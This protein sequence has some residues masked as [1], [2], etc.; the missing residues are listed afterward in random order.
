MREY[1]GMLWP[2]V[3]FFS[4]D[5][6][7]KITQS[8]FTSFGSYSEQCQGARKGRAT[9]L[10]A[11]MQRSYGE[12]RSGCS[13]GGSLGPSSSRQPDTYLGSSPAP[14]MLGLLRNHRSRLVLQQMPSAW[15]DFKFDHCHLAGLP[16]GTKQKQTIPFLSKHFQIPISEAGH[17]VGHK[18]FR[19]WTSPGLS[20]TLSPPMNVSTNQTMSSW[21][22]PL[23]IV[24]SL[25]TLYT[26]YRACQTV[27]DGGCY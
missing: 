24:W 26:Q 11:R 18:G 20:K 25:N 5:V 7:F 3:L 12:C 27:S 9:Y 21:F 23:G 13:G 2:L 15:W 17:F 10:T 22:F 8:G 1:G 14:D 4:P 16:S 6:T 19:P